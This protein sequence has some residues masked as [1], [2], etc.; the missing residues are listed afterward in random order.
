MNLTNFAT[1]V[2]MT[3]CLFAAMVVVSGCGAFKG[4]ENQELGV[5]IGAGVTVERTAGGDNVKPQTFGKPANV[6]EECATPNNASAPCCKSK[7]ATTCD[8]SDCKCCK[9]CKSAEQCA[10]SQCTCCA[11]CKDKAAATKCDCSD[12]KCCKACKSGEK[13]TCLSC[14]CCSACKGKV[15]A[16]TGAAV[17]TGKSADPACKCCTDCQRGKKCDCVDCGHCNSDKEHKKESGPAK[18]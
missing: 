5:G 6:K 9:A 4:R 16:S 18:K 2:L 8:C 15:K 10:C 11:A 14:D 1:R 3:G 13:C 12:C 7:T 17:G